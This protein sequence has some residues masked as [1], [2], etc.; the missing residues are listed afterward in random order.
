MRV[1]RIFAEFERTYKQVY[2]ENIRSKEYVD[3]K[4][5]IA[6]ELNKIKENQTG[7][8]RRYYKEIIKGIEKSNVGLNQK[9]EYALQDCSDIMDKV[10]TIC[11][12]EHEKIENISDRLGM[13]RNDM[14][15]GEMQYKLKPIDLTDINILEILIY[16]VL[17]KS[18][19]LTAENIQSCLNDI[20][21]IH[22][23]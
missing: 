15:H 10:I 2:G 20:F 3:T 12:Q 18:I 6:N 9:I 1:S 11:Y 17:F 4:N 14:I 19:D 16:V 5:E 22:I 21:R 13:L 23:Q 7:Q 8:K